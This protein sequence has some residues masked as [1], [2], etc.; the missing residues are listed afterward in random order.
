MGNLKPCPFCGTKAK[1]SKAKYK[2]KKMKAK[3]TKHTTYVIG[4][5]DPECILYN[6]GLQARLLFTVSNKG[7][8]T[9]TKRWN[10]RPFEM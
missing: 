7:L 6:S 2:F 3:K 10:R 4:C 9:M 8:E 5:S 1:I